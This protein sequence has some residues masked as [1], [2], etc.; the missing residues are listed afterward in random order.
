MKCDLRF[1]LKYQ[2]WL[3]IYLFAA[4]LVVGQVQAGVY[5]I[6]VS[7]YKTLKQAQVDLDRLKAQGYEAFVNQTHLADSGNW[8]RVYTGQ[9]ETRK[10]AQYAADEMKNRQQIERIFIHY[11]PKVKNTANLHQGLSKAGVK[12][13]ERSGKKRQDDSEKKVSAATGLIQQNNKDSQNKAIKNK[14]TFNALLMGDK[15]LTPFPPKSAEST[16]ENE[17]FAKE[18]DEKDISEPLSTSD[19]YNQALA[20]LKERRFQQS[21]DLFK[22]FISRPDTS[23][24]WGQRALRHMADCHY[25]LGKNGSKEDLLIAAEFYKNTLESFP[26]PR[27]ENAL[28]YYRL[29][30]TYESL[31]YF[32]EAIKQYQ[33]LIDKYPD[34][35]WAPEAYFR[36]G[37]IYYADG[38]YTQA[39][40]ALIRYQLKYRGGPQTKKSYYMIA[41][42]FYKGKQ[43]ANAE[44]WFR[45]AR[46]KWTD[47]S[48]IPHEL[49]LDYADHKMAMRRYDEAIEAFSFYVNLYPKDE[50]TKDIAIKLAGAYREAGQIAPALAV[51]SRLIEKYPETEEAKKSI[52]AMASLGVDYPTI[53]VFRFLNHI[54]YFRNP[55]DTFDMLIMRNPT[56]DIGEEAMLQKAAA[57]VKKGE[58][59]KA[60]DVYLE[61]LRL[62]PESKR[63]ANASSGLKTASAALIE[64][65]YAKKDYLAVAYVYFRSYGAVPLQ[66]DEYAQVNKIA[67]SL[68]EMGFID[69]YLNVL[70]RYLKVAQDEAVVHQVH[71]AIAEGLVLQGNYDEAQ[72]ILNELAVKPTIRKGVLMVGIRKT[73]AD[74]A[75]MRQQYAEAAANYDAMI[76]S[77]LDVPEPGPTYY[78]YARALREKK[79][80]SQALQN[81]LTAVQYLG[82]EKS[83][84]EKTGIVYKEIG[85][86]YLIKDNP[87]I[88]LDMYSKAFE[89]AGDA[90]LKFWSQFLMGKTYMRMNKDDQA[91]NV[92]TQMKA[93]SGAEGFW[94]K[95]TDFYVAD[96]Y[97]WNKY[98]ES[99]SR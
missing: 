25:W 35:P 68:K 86:L 29:A 10:K 11:L 58:G 77:G 61:F 63:A 88:S 87:V 78:K 3:A 96:Y 97:W 21:L 26:D 82:G 92:F 24:E 13:K 83:E 12:Q 18:P 16:M 98:G 66:A 46:K 8:Y 36:I 33:N 81:Y 72:K 74:I 17:E 34:A 39:A 43:S 53:K 57:L 65:Y 64:E 94:T 22:E 84:K 99:I 90:E 41:H 9:F 91:Q 23:K 40:E 15:K 54:Q 4:I 73:M 76:R 60:A 52:L 59:R 50:K 20:H 1:S 49:I 6:H 7:S 55:M 45:E 75:Y 38:K 27:K 2:F 42:A 28:T 5:T 19:L 31:K 79:E 95:V 89:A 47:L 32:P 48:D 44:V 56:G 62:Y 85:D 67:L 51:Y 71:L 30:K 69:D 93:A 14:E 37:D 80:N 70:N